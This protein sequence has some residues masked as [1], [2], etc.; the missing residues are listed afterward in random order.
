MK[1][2]QLTTWRLISGGVRPRTASPANGWAGSREDPTADQQTRIQG[3]SRVARGGGWGGATFQPL[4]E[5]IGPPMRKHVSLGYPR[6]RPPLLVT[7]RSVARMICRVKIQILPVYATRG[8]R[9]GFSS[10]LPYT[11]HLS[12]RRHLMEIDLRFALNTRTDGGPAKS[13]GQGMSSEIAAGAGV[14]SGGSARAGEAEC[15]MSSGRNRS[16]GSEPEI[17]PVGKLVGHKGSVTAL[18]I[19]SSHEAAGHQQLVSGSED[20]R[21]RAGWTR[22][23][24]LLDK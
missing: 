18:S 21:C 8:Q 14:P 17:T 23:L 13:R 3:G 7:I 4:L 15:G 20:G 9:D 2:G 24:P 10:Q 19:D 12:Q 5:Y 16:M 6:T 1:G 22:E 11:C